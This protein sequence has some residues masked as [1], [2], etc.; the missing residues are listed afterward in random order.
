MSR[1]K[2]RGWFGDSYRHYLAAKGIKTRRFFAD[3]RAM[4]PGGTG[5]FGPSGSVFGRF[6]EGVQ[7]V[8]DQRRK[9]LAVGSDAFSKARLK[10]A[11]DE[12]KAPSLR[13]LTAKQRQEAM[14]TG[15]TP[16][17]LKLR[18]K[19]LVSA[20]IGATQTQKA[21]ARAFDFDDIVADNIIFKSQER[22]KSL[23]LR[24][25]EMRDENQGKL[26]S[27]EFMQLSDAQ[28]VKVEDDLHAAI[29]DEQ[30]NI[31]S[32]EK[33]IQLYKRLRRVWESDG[34]EK[35]LSDSKDRFAAGRAVIEWDK[36]KAREGR[37]LT[38]RLPSDEDS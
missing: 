32:V 7:Q 3:A 9:G 37:G 22:K 13:G 29:E 34:I 1:Y 16:D 24:I 21:N 38:L 10:Q 31:E 14:Q 20:G 19:V 6:V 27:Q 18:K 25:D 11:R 8:S 28:Q 36:L 17:E 2:K 26:S 5:A 4:G 30:K 12:A 23:A 35:V 15:L 33:E